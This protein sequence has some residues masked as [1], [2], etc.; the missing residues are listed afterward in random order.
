MKRPLVSVVMPS[1]NHGEFVGRA[2]ES[3]LG[4][5]YENFEFIIADDGSTDNS[6]EVISQY[7]DSRIRFIRFEK[8]TSFGACEYIYEQAQGKYIAGI[9]SDDMWKET[10]LEK[11]VFF[12]EN[13]E[14]YGCC[15][16][17]PEI[18]DANDAP[19]EDTI[20]NKVFTEQNLSRGQ[21]FR[22]LY[23]TGNCLCAP[24]MCLRRELYEKIG[25]L[26]F[27]YRQI[28]DWEY[29]MRLLQVSNIY[30]Y[31]ETLCRYR[32]H[33]EG[34]NH[35]ISSPTKE[36]LV[37]GRIES[38]YVL[39]D[40]MEHTT[41]D[42]FMEAFQEDLILEPTAEGFCIECEKFRV[43]LK[44]AYAD[45]AINYYFKHYNERKFRECVERFYNVPRSE[46]WNLTGIDFDYWYE[47][48]INMKKTEEL[49]KQ[50]CALKQ[51]LSETQ[52]ELNEL[53]NK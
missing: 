51:Q 28:Q 53:K 41:P 31:P 42:F 29:W 7:K 5:T 25:P 45:T 10:L 19:I 36:S 14:E 37:R 3:V 17:K 16:C 12:L 30:I 48:I 2:I 22:K 1:Y 46:F 11:Y 27:Q 39:L 34:E 6:A 21:W 9:C 15:F 52:E 18:V 47:N 50:V 8:N 35:N 24:S 33:S 23:L 43:M 49:M 38:K 40:I 26:R 32:V 4:Q 20:F 13:N 44:S